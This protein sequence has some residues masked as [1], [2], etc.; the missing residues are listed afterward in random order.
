V[1]HAEQGK[2]SDQEPRPA[3]A[4]A[5]AEGRGADRQA[6]P[7]REQQSL[8]DKLGLDTDLALRALMQLMAEGAAMLDEGGRIL[9]CNS[10][11]GEML[12]RPVGRLVGESF[13][14]FVHERDEGKWESAFGRH[15][16]PP[17]MGFTL[18][19]LVEGRPVPVHVAICTLSGRP[20]RLA[21]LVASDLAWQEQ[22]MKQLE[23][24][25]VELEEQREALEI[26]ATTDST[27]GAYASGAVFEVLETELGY[28]RRYGYPVSVLLMDVDHFK[29]LND[30]YGHAFGD[31]VLKEFCDRCREAVRATDYLVRYGG[32]EFVVILPQTPLGGARAVGERIV[33]SVRARP[34]GQHEVPVTISV[35]VATAAPQEDLTGGDLLKF[36][37]AALYEVKRAGRDGIACRKPGSGTEHGRGS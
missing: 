16:G 14:S 22:R 2:H 8:S 9:H 24:L 4:E 5:H 7:G 29:F 32:D 37:D 3:G 25:N 19:V 36:A 10:R 17:A 6:E 20:G 13:A 18:Q 23:R 34:F 35:G 26:A 21:I 11:L 12:G 15:G 28:G 30:S 27:T 1:S 31:V 33:E